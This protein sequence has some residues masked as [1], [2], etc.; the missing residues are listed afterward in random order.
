MATAIVLCIGT[1]LTRGELVNTNASFL[2]AGLTSAGFQVIAIDTLDDDA[3]R[4]AAALRRGG[5][6]DVLVATGGLGPTTDDITT[7]CV[8]A[9]LGVDLERDEASLA[10]IRSRFERMGR[11]MSES[12]QK[13]ADFPRGAT[14]IPNPNGTAPGFSVRIARATAFFLPGVPREMAP[15]FDDFVIPA[16]ASLVDEAYHQVLLRTYGL[17][18]SEVNDRLAGIQAEFG[19]TVGYRATF[20]V[21]EVKL[22]AHD[23]ERPVAEARA[24]AA[25]NEV[26]ARLG[27]VVFG[28][29]DVSFAQALGRELVQK[30]WRLAAAE[31][32]T[33][34]LVG[35]I[36]T[37]RP[38]SSAF[39]LGSAVAYDN[40][41][42]AALLG[43]DPELIRAHGAVSSEVARAMA[44]GAR[45][46]FD[47]EVAL[48][49]TGVAGPDGGTPEKPVGLVHYAVSTS[50]GTVDKHLFFA[51]DR[52]LIRTR[53]AYAA[54]GLVLRC[55][56]GEG[57]EDLAK[58]PR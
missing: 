38:G 27:S 31:S 51:G 1:E 18:E 54:L 37:D 17:P 26:K 15:M 57:L 40:G 53:A 4:I 48:S 2:A 16:V 14:V 21:I 24:R 13:Q 30:N 9:E 45:S 3:T 34:G 49:I 43:V 29:G 35:K 20:P 41:A 23:K 36:L 25:A 5:H 44:E 12:N 11:T 28:E 19:V 6:A 58:S 55:A 39:F 42:K 8:A 46:R 7:A 33:G 10:A 52:E 32:C 47:A 22:L 50:E 56:R